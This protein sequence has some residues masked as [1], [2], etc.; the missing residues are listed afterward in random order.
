MRL[1]TLMFGAL[2][3]AVPLIAQPAAAA[4]LAL[5]LLTDVSG[6]MDAAEY[7]MVKD[8]YRAAFALLC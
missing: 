5:V 3:A 6:S 2:L 1:A 4:D 7:G 8:G